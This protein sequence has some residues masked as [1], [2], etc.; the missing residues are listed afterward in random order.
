M[1]QTLKQR[2]WDRTRSEAEFVAVAHL[3]GWCHN[4]VVCPICKAEDRAYQAERTLD[5][6]ISG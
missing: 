6:I 4:S 2:G 3:R 5:Q 1:A